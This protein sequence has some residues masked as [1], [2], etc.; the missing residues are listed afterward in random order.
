MYVCIYIHTHT[1]VLL[2]FLGSK[3]YLY[4]QDILTAVM[5]ITSWILIT[6]FHV[7]PHFSR[8]LQI[9]Y[10]LPFRSLLPPHTFRNVF[11]KHAGNCLTLLSCYILMSEDLELG[12]SDQRE[13]GIFV[14]LGLGF[15]ICY[16]SMCSH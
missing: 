10:A 5:L 15:L 14:F 12:T 8:V 7:F 3:S 6:S 1:Y 13:T 4:D 11:R 2:L 16:L 9:T